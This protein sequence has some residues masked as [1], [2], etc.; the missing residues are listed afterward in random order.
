M[1]LVTRPYART[2]SRE[3]RERLDERGNEPTSF[4]ELRQ[5]RRDVLRDVF[6]G[7]NEQGNRWK[8]N[9]RR[10]R[11]RVLRRDLVDSGK[12]AEGR[13]PREDDVDAGSGHNVARRYK[14]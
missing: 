1:N 14:T 3:A 4:G 6:S 13:S 9:G 2:R 11:R 8:N 5:T 12:R 10:R 7:T